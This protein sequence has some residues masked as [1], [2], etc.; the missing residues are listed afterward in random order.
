MRKMIVSSL[1]LASIGIGSMGMVGC[2]RTVSEKSQTTTHSDG[3]QTTTDQKTVQHP[4]GSVST[5]KDTSHT[6]GQ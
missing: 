2:D 3:S 4:D 6:S 1:M 5:Q